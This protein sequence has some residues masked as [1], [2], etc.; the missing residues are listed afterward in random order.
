MRSRHLL[1]GHKRSSEA[2]VLEC[3][4]VMIDALAPWLLEACLTWRGLMCLYDGSE[5]A[6]AWLVRLLGLYDGSEEAVAWLVR[7][8]G[9]GCRLAWFGVVDA[10][11]DD[12]VVALAFTRGTVN[13]P[14]L[15]IVQCMS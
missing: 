5:E 14:A 8:L 4:D 1:L 3:F 11:I 10:R 9:G 12:G 6:V 7:R 15:M 13:Q 2:L